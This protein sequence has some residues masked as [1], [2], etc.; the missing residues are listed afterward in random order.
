MRPGWSNIRICAYSHLEIQVGALMTKITTLCL[1]VNYCICVCI[2]SGYNYYRLFFLG[3]LKINHTMELQKCA[4]ILELGLVAN[5]MFYCCCCCT[6]CFFPCTVCIMML[7]ITPSCF[8]CYNAVV[9][10]LHV[11][12]ML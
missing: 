4:F 1:S 3:R 11:V 12:P 8:L 7:C 6:P 5:T 9:I 10:L 2:Y